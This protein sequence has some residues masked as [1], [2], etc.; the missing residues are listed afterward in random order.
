MS[1]NVLIIDD[2][3]VFAAS[4]QQALEANGRLA[5]VDYKVDL[6]LIRQQS[7][8]VIIVSAELPGISGLSLCGRVRKAPEL[9]KTSVLLVANQIPPETI[10]KHAE[11]SERADLY[12][13]KPLSTRHIVQLVEQLCP[14]DTQNPP[15]PQSK[16]SSSS[17]RP[18][19]LPRSPPDSA[20]STE[21]IY[22]WPSEHF[23][24]RMRALPLVNPGVI[25]R[26]RW[27][28][29][30]QSPKNQ[31]EAFQQLL[32]TYENRE[33]ALGKLIQEMNTRG[34]ELAR[35]LND[36]SH[37]LRVQ[38]T[39]AAASEQGRQS[40]EQQLLETE[41][42]FRTF[43]TDV[44]K[45]F[46]E[47]A[48]GEQVL[49]SELDTTK[50]RITRLESAL[51]TTQQQQ[52]RELERIETQNQTE[53]LA[54]LGTLEGISE[55]KDEELKNL[56]RKTE[57]QS[58]ELERLYK[59]LEDTTLQLKD[60]HEQTHRDQE[61]QEV[62]QKALQIKTEE[63][64]TL[65]ATKSSKESET[66]QLRKRLSARDTRI[67]E[68]ETLLEK[69]DQQVAEWRELLDEHIA[70]AETEREYLESQHQGVLQQKQALQAQVDGLT[71][72]KIKQEEALSQ[73]L[74]LLQREQELHTQLRS[75]TTEK[76][77]QNDT[78]SELQELIKQLKQEL[79]T[80]QQ[81]H[82]NKVSGLE[83]DL[84]ELQ[85]ELDMSH[86][87]AAKL[88]TKLDLF[89][90]YSNTNE[91]Q[92]NEALLALQEASKEIKQLEQ[93]QKNPTKPEEL[94]AL[95]TEQERLKANIVA[96]EQ[97]CE[98]WT[99][100]FY[101]E[102]KRCSMAYERIKYLEAE[103]K[104]DRNVRE[105]LE[106]NSETHHQKVLVANKAANAEFNTRRATNTYSTGRPQLKK[107]FEEAQHQA[108]ASEG[109]DGLTTRAEDS[110]ISN[111]AQQDSVSA[112]PWP[113]QTAG[114]P[115][116]TPASGKH[117]KARMQSTSAEQSPQ[118]PQSHSFGVPRS[119]TVRRSIGPGSNTEQPETPLPIETSLENLP[120]IDDEEREVT[121]VANLREMED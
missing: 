34:S 104:K 59:A 25:R 8:S 78:L 121:E 61:E 107:L 52:E 116:V 50:H 47:K 115:Q 18:P 100:Q 62:L 54:K 72:E 58:I 111:E 53:I 87:C 15:K 67:Q 49:R 105:E 71:A 96:L 89:V 118:F 22:H 3:Q 48:Q 76:A 85:Q 90:E 28:S 14:L 63:C 42:R 43:H 83:T 9:R 36:I 94:D 101:M 37:S 95:H 7:P 44:E 77:T 6:D 5:S 57:K 99:N 114:L 39:R 17:A 106:K 35:Q 29:K 30:S 91:S 26:T 40:I 68:I 12:A 65:V 51:K 110:T 112:P 46:A 64:A 10:R 16:A 113:V 4:V 13:Y 75:L 33:R 45:V 31:I 60:L 88:E 86:D 74:N 80:S 93:A 56:I 84:I 102:Q 1:G 108:T 73:H 55:L 24:Q 23:Q 92:L 97:S 27:A 82:E 119:S 32:S 19:S 41:K 2:D 70:Q 81:A 11:G 117:L 69:R 20:I 103:H 120:Y 109:C 38:Q 79:E 66:E 21:P 98:Q